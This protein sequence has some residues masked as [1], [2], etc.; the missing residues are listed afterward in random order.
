MQWLGFPKGKGNLGIETKVTMPCEDRARDWDDTRTTK[1]YQGFPA[2]I[3]LEE[4]EERRGAD[5]SSEPT[6]GTNPSTLIS[7][8]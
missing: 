6:E 1:G 8:F 7:D 2:N 5:S 4:L 3:K